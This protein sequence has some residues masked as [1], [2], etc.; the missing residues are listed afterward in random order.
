MDIIVINMV[1]EATYRKAKY[2]AK[3]D[4]DVVRSR[5]AS[6]KS[7]MTEQ[8]ESKAAELAT[9]E[10]NIKAILE[11]QTSPIYSIQVPFYL[12]VGR[13]LYRLQKKFGGK[14]FTAEAIVVLDKWKSRGLTQSVLGAIA[15]LFGVTYPPSS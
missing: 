9:I 2:E 12:N 4:A 14:T 3:I 10:K 5:I 15:E 7:S 1:R 13:E 8:M 6:L 11:A